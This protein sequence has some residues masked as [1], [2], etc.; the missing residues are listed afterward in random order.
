VDLPKNEENS[1]KPSRDIFADVE[2]AE[3]D[4]TKPPDPEKDKPKVVRTVKKGRAKT[5]APRKQPT[6]SAKNSLHPSKPQ[7]RMQVQE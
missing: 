7:A 1:N 6:R 4:T 5:V 3:K 2:T